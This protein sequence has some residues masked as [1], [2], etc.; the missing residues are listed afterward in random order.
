MMIPSH[1]LDSHPPSLSRFQ[2]T[3]LCNK[4]VRESVHLMTPPPNYP[5]IVI[6]LSVQTQTPLFAAHN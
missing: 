5:S 1:G 2:S 4:I 3:S 6:P